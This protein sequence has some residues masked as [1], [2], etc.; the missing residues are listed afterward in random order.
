MS[1]TAARTGT[2][3][4]VTVEARATG[5]SLRALSGVVQVYLREIA[6][7]PGEDPRAAR[8]RLAIVEAVT[9]VIR[10]G[11][12]GRESGPVTLSLECKGDRLKCVLSDHADRFNPFD[13]R[14]SHGLVMDTVRHRY[15]PAAGNE[16][17][18]TTR[19]GG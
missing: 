4:R 17:T 14:R 10:H 15:D 3:T 5:D 13:R 2:A 1:E 11:Y 8:I 9:H 6:G 18:M 12:A 16:L 19:L 7:L